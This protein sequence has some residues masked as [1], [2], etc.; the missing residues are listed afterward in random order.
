MTNMGTGVILT[1][2]R[3]E[4]CCSERT[5]KSSTTGD[6]KWLINQCNAMLHLWSLSVSL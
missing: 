2:K 1:C 4:Q 6:Y 3:E 5:C